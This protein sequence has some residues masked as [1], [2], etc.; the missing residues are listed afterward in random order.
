M[1]DVEGQPDGGMPF[2]KVRL[3]NYRVKNGFFTPSKKI[4]LFSST[5]SD[6]GHD[7]IPNASLG[8]RG[9]TRSATVGAGAW[10]AQRPRTPSS[11]CC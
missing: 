7:G 4:E 10:T 6:L 5:L 9:S 3:G 1:Q 2:G 11:P 8:A